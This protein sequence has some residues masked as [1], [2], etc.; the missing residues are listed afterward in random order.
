MTENQRL[1]EAAKL[2][3]HASHRGANHF[4]DGVKDY[5][6]THLTFVNGWLMKFIHLVPDYL[7]DNGVTFH[8]VLEAA[9]WLHDVI[10]DCRRTP[11]DLIKY[12]VTCGFSNEVGYHIARLVF[13]VSN[14][15][16][17]SRG[18][19]AN[20]KYYSDMLMVDY[21]DWVKL[22]DRFGNMEYSMSVGSS[23]A[24][25]YKAEYSHFRDKLYR[26]HGNV[27]YVWHELDKLT[28]G[29]DS[30]VFVGSVVRLAGFG[31]SA[32]VVKDFKS[33]F[34]ESEVFQASRIKLYLHLED[35]STN[36]P[37]TRS[38]SEALIF[39]NKWI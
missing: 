9:T 14:E 38:A 22:A 8:A 19:R 6:D 34:E 5:F 26:R 20:A 10:E 21:A 32:F 37:I 29:S 1:V 7:L 12:F 15:K 2:Y 23:M 18:D 30:N 11:N 13:A 17:W 28:Y 39:H 16:G 24:S 25:K 27:S 31:D 35:L 33:K 4:Y 36:A 3:A